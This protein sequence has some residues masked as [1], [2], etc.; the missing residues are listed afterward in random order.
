I[1]YQNPFQYPLF[2]KIDNKVMYD[3]FDPSYKELYPSQLEQILKDG[4]FK[5]KNLSQNEINEIK[6]KEFLYLNN[7][8]KVFLN[9]GLIFLLHLLVYSEFCVL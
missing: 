4:K 1:T 8:S 6:T 2:K 7:F 3:V 9:I 5:G